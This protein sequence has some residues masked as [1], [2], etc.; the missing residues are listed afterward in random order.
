[1]SHVVFIILSAAA[2]IGAVGVVT[3]RNLFRAAL[4]L[5]LSF[6]GVA[7]LYVLLEAEMLA[8]VQLLVYVGAIS[9]LI[10]FAIMLS[11]RMMSPEFK[12]RN[13]QWL[14]GLVFSVALFAILSVILLAVA[15]PTAQAA[16]PDDAIS[17]LGQALVS[18]DQYVLVFEAASVL[19]LVALVGAVVIARER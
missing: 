3:T 16:V 17:L 7:G 12:T 10:I 2:L 6:V 4:F 5:V 11:R 13:E 1:M 15:W 18:P 14:L 8:M 9:I 19:L